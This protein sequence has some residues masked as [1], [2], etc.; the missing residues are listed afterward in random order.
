LCDAV[1]LAPRQLL[2]TGNMTEGP[3]GTLSEDR[4]V[5]GERFGPLLSGGAEGEADDRVPRGHDSL[6]PARAGADGSLRGVRSARC[7]CYPSSVGSR[8]A[9]Q[10]QR[11]LTQ[12]AEQLLGGGLVPEEHAAR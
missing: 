9:R 3:V 5:H 8:R 1:A 2:R 7:A 10:S 11:V 4:L 12:A 6:I